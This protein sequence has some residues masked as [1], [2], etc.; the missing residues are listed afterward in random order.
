MDFHI[1]RILWWASSEVNAITS[2]CALVNVS[3]GPLNIA[4]KGFGSM[5]MLKA[6][7]GQLKGI[8]SQA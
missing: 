8:N 2:D 3:V 4:L 1:R 6:L 5:V 7:E